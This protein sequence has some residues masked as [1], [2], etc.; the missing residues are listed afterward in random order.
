MSSEGTLHYVQAGDCIASI[1]LAKGHFPK[2]LW[3]HAR[4]R[5]LQDLRKDP[6]VLF[7][8]DEVFVP[9]VRLKEE[10]RGSD[11][12]H[13]FR[14]K[15]VPAKLN[16]QLMFNGKPRANIPYILVI[17]G[18]SRDGQTDGD[19]WVK[20]SIPPNAAEG[21]LR[22]RPEGKPEEVFVL[23]LGHLDPIETVEGQKA[24]LRNLGC[25]AGDIDATESDE[26]AAAIRSFQKKHDLE[27]TGTMN[28]ATKSKLKSEHQS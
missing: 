11:Q 6:N 13:R 9:E 24:R 16:L 19:G 20:E 2:T 21:T 1:A 4:N 25:F 10:S 23:N 15:G 14:R 18:A 7:V 5:A 17:D 12:K 22:L 27:I 28:D 3:D 8:G 26:F